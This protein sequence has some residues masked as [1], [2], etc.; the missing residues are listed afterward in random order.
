MANKAVELT[1]MT[2]ILKDFRITM[3]S[4]PIFYCDNLIVLFMTVNLIFHA[5]SKHIE[6]DYYFVRE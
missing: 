2:F 4:P 6:L 1:W 5:R 3:T